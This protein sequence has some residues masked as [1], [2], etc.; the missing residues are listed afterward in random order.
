MR[1]KTPL[2]GINNRNLRTFEV[3]LDTTLALLP[4]LPTDRLLVTESGILGRADVERMR[5]AGVQCLSGRRGLHAGARPGCG[6]GGTLRLNRLTGPLR[7]Q[8]ERPLGDWQPLLQ[9]WADRAE[10]RATMAAVDA[11]VA[12]GAVVYPAR[13]FRALEL[14]PLSATRVVILGQ[15]PYHG[16]GQ[17]EGL[18]FS[19]APGQRL[20]PSLR[21]IYKEL[22]RDL[23]LPP[24]ASG[25]LLAWAERGVLL[26]NTSLTVE[27]G[28]PASHSKLGWHVL[29]D[30]ICLALLQDVVA[31]SLHA[32]GRPRASPAAV[33]PARRGAPGA[34]MQPSLATFGHARGHALH[35]LRALWPGQSLLVHARS[36]GG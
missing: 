17:A 30:A 11:R 24:P 2:V 4:Q 18:A 27:D 34:R 31:E 3:T 6:A 32:L 26:L 33:G 20:P 29:T 35:R 9:R 10:G 12:A 22:Q 7:E 23:G 21:N 1:L 14:T 15:D 8:L 36:R 16:A 5:A 28:R 25:S 19:V 13:V